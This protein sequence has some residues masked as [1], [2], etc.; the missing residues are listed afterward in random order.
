[1]PATSQDQRGSVTNGLTELASFSAG[2]RSTS[3][4]NT[5]LPVFLVIPA[6]CIRNQNGQVSTVMPKFQEPSF[7]AESDRFKRRS[8]LCAGG[9]AL[10]AST[11]GGYGES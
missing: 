9:L 8:I 11:L 4:R 3:R 6:A 2:A 7:A 5:I 1:M 10:S